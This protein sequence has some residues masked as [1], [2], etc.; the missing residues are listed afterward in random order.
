MA[1]ARSGNFHKARRSRS[2]KVGVSIGRA[3]RSLRSLTHESPLIAL[4]AVG[5]G[6]AFVFGATAARMKLSPLLGYLFAGVLIG[7]FTPGF[8][9][10]EGLAQEVADV[11][12]ILLMFGVGLHFSPR[13]LMAVRAVAVPMTL[14]MIATTIGLGV[15][16]SI[17]LGWG[18]EAGI[19]FGLS[20]SVASTVVSLRNLQDRK[21]IQTERGKLTVAW[22][23]VEDVAMVLA[24]VP[25]PTWAQIRSQAVDGAFITVLQLQDV[26]LATVLTLRKV[27]LFAV[28][29]MVAGK[30]VVPWVLHRVVQMGSRELFRLCVLAIVLGWPTPPRRYS[31]FRWRWA[32]C[33]PG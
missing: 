16:A 17:M 27:A 9:A 20:L 15:G 24:M 33:S 10:I 7:P 3:E 8:I 4:L 25:L 28:I 19:V 6:L 13:D 32:H 26:G 21:V 12:V 31:A 14:L 18:I 22:L 2:A 30:R 5:F 1:F 29:M 23:V 11:G